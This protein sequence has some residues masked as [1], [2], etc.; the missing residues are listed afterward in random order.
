MRYAKEI[1]PA[2]RQFVIVRLATGNRRSS[3]FWSM[4]AVNLV[5]SVAA[6]GVGSIDFISSKRN[7]LTARY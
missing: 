6:S 2:R 1:F 3:S 5:V 7:R 4:K